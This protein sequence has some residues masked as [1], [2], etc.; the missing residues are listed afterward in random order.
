MHFRVTDRVYY[1]FHC[2]NDTLYCLFVPDVFII[3]PAIS[4]LCIAQ[5]MKLAVKTLDHLAFKSMNNFG[6]FRDS[7]SAVIQSL[8][9]RP[10][11]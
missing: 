10:T 7:P 9:K 3:T 1:I 4:D 5:Q 6:D 2:S 8:L 11:R